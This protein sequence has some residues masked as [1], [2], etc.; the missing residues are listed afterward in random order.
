MII[1]SIYIPKT[2]KISI[3]YVSCI[4][5]SFFVS[6]EINKVKSKSIFFQ[7]EEGFEVQEAR[8]LGC[9]WLQPRTQTV[10]WRF[11]LSRPKAARNPTL[12]TWHPKTATLTL[13]P[14]R[15]PQGNAKDE[16][17]ALMYPSSHVS[18]ITFPRT[19]WC[20]THAQVCASFSWSPP[21]PDL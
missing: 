16:V 9:I 6:L 2:W 17:F 21:S 5:L 19:R 14:L 1:I 11:P 15:H 10:S 8:R 7:E 20:W 18:S 12:Q 4:C 13:S 3:L